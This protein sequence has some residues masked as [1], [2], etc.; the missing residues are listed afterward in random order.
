MTRIVTRSDDFG[1]F[2]TANKAIVD[3]VNDGIVK[4]V[5]IMVVTDY[6]RE[7]STALTGKDICLGLHFCINAEWTDIDWKPISPVDKVPS[8]VNEACCFQTNIREQE[9]ASLDEIMLECKAQLELARSAG[10]N[11]EYLDTHCGFEWFGEGEL[12]NRLN[13]FCKQERLVYNGIV[14]FDRLPSPKTRDI[15]GYVKS[16]KNLS[17]DKTY[18][19]IGHPCYPVEEI[20]NVVHLGL[21]PGDVAKD[22]DLQRD[23]FLN[24]K[25]VDVCKVAKVQLIKYT[26]I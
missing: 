26:Q 21:N 19:W 8:L 16:I 4:N 11:I 14:N 5:S 24:S 12:R 25:I 1:S 23:M 18:L 6:W 20:Q 17:P 9:H 7:A 15:D 10:L 2:K 13:I 22:R 3:C